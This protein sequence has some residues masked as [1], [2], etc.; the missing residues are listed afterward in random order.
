MTVEGDAD[1]RSINIYAARGRA[2][3]RRQRRHDREASARTSDSAASSSSRTST[4][5]ASRTAT[6]ARSRRRC[7]SRRRPTSSS[8][9]AATPSRSRRSPPSR[10][11]PPRDGPP[12]PASQATRPAPTAREP[13]ARE[14]TPTRAAARTARA[15]DDAHTT[16]PDAPQALAG[17][18]A[19]VREP[20]RAR[21]RYAAGGERQLEQQGERLTTFDGY[22]SGP[23]EADP[24]RLPAEAAAK[25][26]DG[27][28][29]HDPRPRRPERPT[30]LAPHVE[31]TIRPAG[32]GA[33]DRPEADP[34]RLEAARGDRDLHAP[35]ARTRSSARDAREP[36]IGQILLMSKEQLISRVLADTRTSRSTRA[37]G[38]T[39]APA[40]STV[41]CS[42]RSSSSSASGL[43]PTVTSLKGGHGYMTALRQRLRALARGT[44]V[45]IAAINGIP[46]QPATQGDGLDRPTSRSAAC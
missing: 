45:D 2:R 40:R 42:R 6:S 13:T 1:R 29:R 37:A 22:F 10:R 46:I 7:R 23:L 27:D 4:A 16:L 18:G 5:T 41:A 39:S 21:R 11:T 30:R 28:R 17:E 33:A 36:S 12:A 31:F 34:R 44:A 24:E 26:L 35:R 20:D 14:P 25:G 38:A 19:A 9:R 8:S 32:R 3:R 15:A 43:K